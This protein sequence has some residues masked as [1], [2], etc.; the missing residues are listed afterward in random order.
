MQ[1]NNAAYISESNNPLSPFN[2][3]KI[4]K[5]RNNPKKVSSMGLIICFIVITLLQPFFHIQKQVLHLH[6]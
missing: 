4:K 3:L 5:I 1:A 2:T 6:L